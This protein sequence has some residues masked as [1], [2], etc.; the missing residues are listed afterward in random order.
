MTRLLAWLALAAFTCVTSNSALAVIVASDHFTAEG[1]GIGFAAADDWGN[2]SNGVS[3]TEVASPAFRA[4]DPPI[5]AVGLSS[6]SVYVSFDFAS[7]QAVNWGG[8]AF[9][10]GIDGGDETLFV[11]MPNGRQNFGIDL[12]GGQGVLDSGVPIDG[13]MHRIVMQIEFG[14]SNDTYRMWVDNLN[15]SLPNNEITLDGFVVDDA[16]Q[17]VRVASDTGAGTFVTVDNLVIADSAASAGLT[18]ATNASLTINRSTGEI[19]LASSSSLSNVVGYTLRSGVGAFDQAAW[20]TIDGRDATDATPAGD[21]SVDNDDWDVLS[22]ADSSTVLSESTVDTTPGDGLTLTSSALSLGNAWQPSPYEDVFATLLIDNN[23]TITP[24]GV[25]VSYTGSEIIAGDLDADGDIDLDDWSSFKAGQGTVSNAMTTL[26]AYR[27]GDMDGNRVHNLDDFD[28]F[29][30]AFDTANG[31]GSFAA[32]VSGVPEPSSIALLGICAGLVLGIRRR[33]AIIASMVAVTLTL[34]GL[35]SSAQAVIYASDD[36]EADGS[37]TGWAIGDIWETRDAGGFLST[38]ANGG[39]NTFSS[40]NFATPIDAQNSLTYIRFDYRQEEGNG[41]NWGGFAFFEGLDASADESYFAGANPGGTNNYGFDVKGSGGLLDSLISF[42]AQ[43]HTVIGSI[44]QTGADTIYKIWIDNFDVNSPNN[45][46]TVAGQNAID[47]PWQSLRF[48]GGGA[49]EIADNLLITD[50]AE[51]SL[52]FDAPLLETLNLLVNK[53]TGEVTI[54]NNTGGSV[55]L[56]A[57]SISS[58]SGSLDTGA[59][60]GDF[61]ADGSVDLADYTVW[62]DNLGGDSSVLNGNGSG[63][64]IVTRTDYN[65]WKANFGG[66]DTGGEGWDSLA[67]RDTPV[68]GFPQS[69]GDGTGW[70][71]G[72]GASLFE[73]EEYRLIGES[74]M[75]TTPI[76]LGAAYAG[77]VDGPNDLSFSY[78]SGGEILYG[79]IRYTT[80]VPTL[81]T[82]NVPEP[83]TLALLVL[84]GATLLIAK[85]SA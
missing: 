17:S 27:L 25:N 76:S 1:G 46:V 40:R 74:T 28:L 37:G 31:A 64:S 4:L 69:A 73:L 78:R 34:I 14:A 36:F 51:E 59:T 32:A 35:S 75:S 30:E 52:I 47:A 50:G 39:G 16:W 84:A 10:E 38:Y 66:V 6:G 45:T 85:R 63:S 62:R 15:Q 58:A 68:A 71:T 41:D 83:S 22:P 81:S 67:D 70:E 53:A 72:D 42:N 3:T 65:I 57:Y 2:L 80:T 55:N 29:A 77:G 8:L 20:T 12:K 21:G 7:N 44:D 43:N 33:S 23:G 18:S 60:V 56:S 13:Q 9:F 24:M 48:S 79:S 61:N 54:E 19:S 49:H 26:E 11:G 82:A 5:D